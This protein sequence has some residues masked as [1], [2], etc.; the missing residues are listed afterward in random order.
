MDNLNSICSSDFPLPCILAS[1]HVLGIWMW[2]SLGDRI[3]L[4]QAPSLSQ[5]S[6][7]LFVNSGLQGRNRWCEWKWTGRQ[8]DELGAPFKGG[9]VDQ[10]W[11]VVITRI[12]AQRCQIFWFLFSE[13]FLCF[14]CY[15][16]QLLDVG[17]A[18]K[19]LKALCKP[20]QAHL[21]LYI[22]PWA[23]HLWPLLCMFP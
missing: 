4:L 10:T 8:R 22:W 3:L 14:L 13:D 1:S 20:N 19:Y 2:T 7:P 6:S 17:N 9:A 5:F 15:I 21:L 23:A 11:P 12:W 18:F 16:S